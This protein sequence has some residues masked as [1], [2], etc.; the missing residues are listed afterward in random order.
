MLIEGDNFM[1]IQLDGNK[2]KA[3]K[4]ANE[5]TEK[6]PKNVL[7]T[8]EEAQQFGRIVKVD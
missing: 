7:L 4:E 5:M 2:I 6:I 8:L 1:S 3:D